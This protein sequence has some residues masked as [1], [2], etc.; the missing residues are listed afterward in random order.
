MKCSVRNTQVL[1][2]GQG[3]VSF[4]GNASGESSRTRH[5]ATEQEGDWGF[6]VLA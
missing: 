2:G 5:W 1:R 4:K 6:L 3:K